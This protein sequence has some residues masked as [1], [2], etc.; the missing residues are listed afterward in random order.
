MKYETVQYILRCALFE[1]GMKFP[2]WKLLSAVKN[3]SMQIRMAV[4]CEEEDVNILRFRPFWE[5]VNLLVVATPQRLLSFITP[6]LSDL[7]LFSHIRQ[8]T[9][10]GLSILSVGN[11][12]NV[13][14]LKLVSVSTLQSFEAMYGL[15][16]LVVDRCPDLEEIIGLDKVPVVQITFCDLIPN[17]LRSKCKKPVKKKIDDERISN[18]SSDEVTE[19]SESAQESNDS[20]FR[21]VRRRRKDVFKDDKASGQFQ[22]D[23]FSIGTV[24]ELSGYEGKVV[25][26]HKNICLHIRGFLCRRD[27]LYFMNTSVELFRQMKYETVRYALTPCKVSRSGAQ[28]PGRSLLWSVKNRSEQIYV[29]VLCEEDEVNVLEF[30]QLWKEVNFLSVR[31]PPRKTCLED[32]GPHLNNLTLFSNIR[33]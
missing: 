20:L 25:F 2:G 4:T 18:R 13:E 11:L 21:N 26:A 23:T 24:V 12:H 32:P 8:L 14:V 5:E 28:F 33:S 31:I 17:L 27:Y 30:E 19:G 7:S 29:D 10:H 9:F 22:P 1:S 15:K 6:H 16:K 3:R